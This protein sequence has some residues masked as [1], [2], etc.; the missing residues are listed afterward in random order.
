M[1]SLWGVCGE[2]GKELPGKRAVCGVYRECGESSKDWSSEV[3]EPSVVPTQ[4]TE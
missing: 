3:N 4:A 1:N 2:L